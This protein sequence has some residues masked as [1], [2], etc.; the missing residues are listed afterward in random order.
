[1]DD[2]ALERAL[3]DLAPALAFPSAVSG[4]TDVASRVR[5]RLVA[6]PPVPSRAGPLD[7]IRRRPVRRSLLV[8]VAALLILAAV[9]GAVGL[10]LP[11]IRIF[12]GG[13]TPPP[14]TQTPKP[15]PS[16]P[17]GVTMGL[18]TALPIEDVARLAGLDLI[19]PPDPSIGPPDVAYLLANRAALVWSARPGLPA[20]PDTGVG[21]L[22]SEFRGNVD[23]GYYGKTLGNGNVVT[24]V[25]VDGHPGYW[26]SGPQHFFYFVDPTGRD[27]DDSHR[28]VGDTLIWSTGDTT[29]R[30]ESRLSMEEAIR[31]AESLR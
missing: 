22:I 9:A 27:V 5:Q 11:G 19:L 20:D 17:L 31:L 7:W 15:A 30:L 16:S 24:P 21:L 4:A 28:V 18:G 1:M 10:G 13:P 6:G 8:A 3:R 2:A 12:F 23:Q 14:A 29:Y 26:I 25:T